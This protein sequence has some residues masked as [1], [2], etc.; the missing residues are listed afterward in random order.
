MNA[1]GPGGGIELSEN[2]GEFKP[3]AAGG[4][5]LAAL[6]PALL[7]GDVPDDDVR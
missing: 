5:M 3:R 7:P 1:K 6:K 2:F 4:E